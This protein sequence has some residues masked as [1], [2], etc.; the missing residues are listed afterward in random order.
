MQ[1][2]ALALSIDRH[3]TSPF[4]AQLHEQLKNLIF[5]GR[6]EDGARLPSTRALALDLGLSRTTLVAVYDQ[7]AAEGLIETR[8][9]AG[10]FVALS[11]AGQTER[12]TNRDVTVESANTKEQ[13][14][15]PIPF[16]VGLPDGPSFPAEQWARALARACRNR[17]A[18]AMQ[19]RRPGGD[20]QLRTAIAEH[21]RTVRGLEVDSDQI[22]ITSGMRETLTVIGQGLLDGECSVWIEDPC[23]PTA[24]RIL[25]DNR[26]RI[27]SIPVDAEGICV[28]HGLHFAPNAA[29]ALVT[30]T[31]QYPLGIT[32]SAGRR[33]ALLEWAQSSG[34]LVIEDDYDSEYRYRGRPLAP[35]FAIAPAGTVIHI[36]SFSKVM[37]AGLRLAYIVAPKDVVPALLDAQVRLGSQAS[38]IPQIGLA[39]FMA[40][41]QFATHIRRSRRLYRRRQAAMID[42]ISKHFSG[43]LDVEAADAGIH[44]I[45]RLS[46]DLAEH[47]G[48]IALAAQARRAGF[49]LDP[50]SPFF[51]LDPAQQGLIFGFAPFDAEQIDHQINRLAGVL[52]N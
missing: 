15:K 24:R 16:E 13:R 7:L 8:R 50:L 37:F 6:L 27:H 43:L 4:Q 9:G 35:L 48:D 25:E 17:G 20:W 26:F 46:A 51:Q 32:L 39:E 22:L 14:N 1:N 33:Q 41:G 23:Y 49:A 19:E 11:L 47:P 38:I 28:Q 30:P 36:G 5:S 12:Q 21:L 40:S 18:L 52:R 31:R 10:A 45:G 42:A 2:A 34:G 3:G 29:A 44:L